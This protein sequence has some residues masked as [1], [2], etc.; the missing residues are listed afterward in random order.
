MFTKCAGDDEKSIPIFLPNVGRAI[1]M[2]R[3]LTLF[4]AEHVPLLFHMVGTVA[5]KHVSFCLKEACSLQ[6]FYHCTNIFKLVILS[7]PQILVANIL[8]SCKG[9]KDFLIM[10]M[11]RCHSASHSRRPE[12]HVTYF[13]QDS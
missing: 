6:E 13:F 2:I 8:C 5:T 4:L 11:C 7:Y 3:E 9:E 12:Q 1:F 10:G